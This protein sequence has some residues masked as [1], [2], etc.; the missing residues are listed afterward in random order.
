M[1]DQNINIVRT[2]KSGFSS[3]SIVIP[4]QLAR[5]AGL[6]EPCYVTIEYANDG[7]LIKKLILD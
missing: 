7:I 6:D 4:K 1:P 2:W 3:T 5:Q